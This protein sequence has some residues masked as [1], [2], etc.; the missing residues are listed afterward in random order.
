MTL[1]KESLK[2]LR[3]ENWCIN[4]MFFHTVINQHQKLEPLRMLAGSACVQVKVIISPPPTPLG[5]LKAANCRTSYFFASNFWQTLWQK[6]PLNVH[7]KRIWQELEILRN[8]SPSEILTL[9][10]REGQELKYEENFS[11]DIAVMDVVVDLNIK[12]FFQT[13]HSVLFFVILLLTIF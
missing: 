12:H 1:S 6:L 9:G 3:G 8:G 7:M 11:C 5:S 13:L 10:M 2:E 4:T